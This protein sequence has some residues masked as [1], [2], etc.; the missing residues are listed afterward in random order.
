MRTTTNILILNMAV[1]DVIVTLIGC[2]IT[3]AWFWDGMLWFGGLVGEI[4]C[5]IC[6][7]VFYLS[8]YVSLFSLLFISMDRFLAVKRPL[9]HKA[10]KGWLKYA[11][12]AT[13]LVA[14]LSVESAMSI[15]LVERGDGKVVCGIR[16]MRRTGIFMMTVFLVMLVAMVFIYTWIGYKLWTRHTPGEQQG[17]VDQ[18]NARTASRATRMIIATLLAFVVC[19]SPSIALEIQGVVTPPSTPAFAYAILYFNGL[20]NVCIYVLMNEKFRN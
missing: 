8:C 11:V 9:Q 7:S 19:W 10:M 12:S 3:V 5:R 20:I 6:F 2:P 4:T 16:D 14:L 1:S 13:W 15:C 17:T 18:R